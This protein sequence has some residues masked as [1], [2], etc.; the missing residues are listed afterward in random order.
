MKTVNISDITAEW[1]AKNLPDLAAALRGEGEKAANEA[2]AN[3]VHE[4]R[5]VA[6]AE[7]HAAGREEGLTEGQAAGAQ[8]ER[9]RIQ[10]IEAA[11]LPG[12]EELIAKLKADP[13]MTVDAA[14][15]AVLKAEQDKHQA[16]LNARKGD[17]GKLNPPD[18][19]AGE[20]D[21]SA[22]ATAK[23]VT[24]LARKAGAIQ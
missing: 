10:G 15:Q 18:P 13:K 7:G 3:A 8:A 23:N 16:A 24:S 17:E 2:N 9:Q 22:E 5:E 1:I 6:R 11:A 14:R 20:E 12:H 19:S 4:A 21:E